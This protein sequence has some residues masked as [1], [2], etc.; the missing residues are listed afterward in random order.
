VS[1]EVLHQPFAFEIRTGDVIRGDVWRPDAPVPGAAVVVCHGFKGFKDWGFF[2]YLAEEMARRTGCLTASFNFTGCGVGEDLE[3]FT[4][5]EGFSRNTISRELGDLEAVLDRLAAGRCGDVQV[6]PADRFGLLGHSR[7]G[8]T[9]ILEAATRS[10]VRGLVTWAAIA[11]LE[12]YVALY[13]ERWDAGQV[14]EIPNAR[15]GQ[16]MPL[17]RNVL[18]DL[19]ANRDRLDVLAAARTLRVPWL[20]VHGT[21]DE[22]VP[23]SDAAML[24]EAGADHAA[25]M[26]VEG[27]GHTFGSGHPF[28]GTSEALEK[29]IERSADLLRRC[30]AGAGA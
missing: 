11:G 12:R 24:A 16:M 30:L 21:E 26:A 10:Q 2:P 6:P 15:T 27:A 5:L 23:F 25:V 3:T 28:A 7:G 8:A 22:S 29:I 19:R 20:V 17:R 13:G 14:V 18:D 1:R 4:D 9:C